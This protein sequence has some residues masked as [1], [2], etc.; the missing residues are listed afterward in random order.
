MYLN[1]RYKISAL[2]FGVANPGRNYFSRLGQVIFPIPKSKFHALPSA[3]AGAAARTRAGALNRDCIIIVPLAR[4]PRKD[5]SYK[6]ERPSY[7]R[8]GLR[9]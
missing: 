5:C 1:P 3:M 7:T 4:I 8:G 2:G 6:G 9:A